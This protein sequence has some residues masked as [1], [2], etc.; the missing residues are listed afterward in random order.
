MYMREAKYKM[1]PATGNDKNKSKRDVGGATK[2][3]SGKLWGAGR[4]LHVI[5]VVL[6][7]FVQKQ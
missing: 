4:V 2:A 3:G 6:F 7:S 1:L 5:T